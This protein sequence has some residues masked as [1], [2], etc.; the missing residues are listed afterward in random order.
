MPQ[1]AGAR[2]TKQAWFSPQVSRCSQSSFWKVVLCLKG[3]CAYIHIYIYEA[4]VAVIF[5]NIAGTSIE[6][7]K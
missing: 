3:V 2:K 7:K 6:M 1:M 4:I 5:L